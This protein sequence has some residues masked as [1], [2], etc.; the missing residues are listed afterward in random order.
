MHCFHQSRGR[1]LFEV[2]CALVISASF[3]GAWMQT[4]ASAL[5]PAAGVAALYGLVHLFDLRR[6]F[7][8]DAVEPQ[9]IEFDSEEQGEPLMGLASGKQ[10]PVAPSVDDEPELAECPEQM[11]SVEP[12][13]PRERKSSRAKAPRKGV[14][15]QASSPEKAK[16]AELAPPEVN[17]TEL[18][19]SGEAEVLVPM[20]SE[21][22][23]H[24]HFE[25]LFEPDP[26]VRMPRRAFGRKAG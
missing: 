1:I 3:V 6:R 18:A 7:P 22:A 26:F 14:S 20:V 9:R 10:D 21:E 11:E 19:P 25:P 12:A 17:V 16:V 4:G 5:L 13:A 24:P 2:L 23:A 8:V 15:R